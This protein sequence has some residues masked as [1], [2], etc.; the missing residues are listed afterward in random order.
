[1]SEL[2]LK[3]TQRHAELLR[4]ACLRHAAH[5]G[6]NTGRTT[7]GAHLQEEEDIRLLSDME[8]LLEDSALRMAANAKQVKVVRSAGHNE[9]KARYKVFNPTNGMHV[10][11]EASKLKVIDATDLLACAAL[12]YEQAGKVLCLIGSI[13]KED[14]AQWLGLDYSVSSDI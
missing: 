3:I 5:L 2:N 9:S 11:I 6:S 12:T 8:A 14:A 13:N 7:L 4:T 10:F 1:M